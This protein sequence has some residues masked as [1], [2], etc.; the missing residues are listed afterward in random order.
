MTITISHMMHELTIQCLGCNR[1]YTSETSWSIKKTNLQIQNEHKAIKNVSVK[2]M[3]YKLITIL[4]LM[5][6]KY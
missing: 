5:I 6:P 2:N 3:I 4:T 1:K